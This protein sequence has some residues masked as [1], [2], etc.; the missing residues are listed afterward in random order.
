MTND[1][2]LSMKPH[3]PVSSSPM[4]TGASPSLNES[5]SSNCGLMTNAPVLSMKPH[6]P[7][8]RS[9]MRTRASPSLNESAK[10]NCRLM[11]ND[12]VLSMNPDLSPMRTRA[13]PSLNEDASSNCGLMTIV[14]VSR[15]VGVCVCADANPPTSSTAT[16]P[17]TH[18]RKFSMS[19]DYQRRRGKHL[20]TRHAVVETRR[21]DTPG[22][23]AHRLGVTWTP[24]RRWS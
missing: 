16:T 3:L 19:G 15:L 8:S 1:P 2:V 11:T 9:P 7:V 13:S 4:R 6:L 12:P 23:P 22:S 5:A 10:S 14:P 18:L 17:T 21:Q 20:N 24:Q